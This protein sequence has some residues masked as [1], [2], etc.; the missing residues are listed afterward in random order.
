[1][2]LEDALKKAGFAHC[3]LLKVDCEGG[4]YDIFFHTPEETLRKIDRI[5]MEY[6]DGCTPHS[7]SELADFLR[8]HGFSITLRTNPVH[9]HIGFL[10][11]VRH[12]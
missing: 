5:A 3:D 2:T 11:A 12:P 10:T 4:E 1:M 6:H 7:H 9:R 8:G